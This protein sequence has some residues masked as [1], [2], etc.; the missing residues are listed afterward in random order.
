MPTYLY[1]ARDQHGLPHTGQ[2]DGL[3]EDDV[4]AVLQRRG[5]LVT[6]ISKKTLAR[7][8]PLAERRIERRP[9]AG[10]TLDDQVLL[11]QQL[12]TLVEAGVPLLKSLEVVSAQIES[13][14]LLQALEHIRHDVRGG[15]TLAAALARHPA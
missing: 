10:V 11:C 7:Q 8:R 1:V 6:S 3:N 9:R 14:A 2:L 15:S 4:V 13:R 5:L 12:A